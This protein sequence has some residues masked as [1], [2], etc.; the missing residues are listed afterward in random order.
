L[1][2]EISR[3][4][5]REIDSQLGEGRS[6]NQSPLGQF[7][8]RL[9]LGRLTIVIFVASC[10][11]Y[12]LSPQ[13]A[14]MYSDLNRGAEITHV[15]L[16]LVQQG[17]FAHPFYYPTGAT[18][19]TAPVYVLLYALVGKLFG[20]GWTG[21][22]VIWALNVGFLALQLAL[23]PVL[24]DRL[25]LGAV[26]G[27]IAA[28]I[29]AV[30]QP[31]RVLPQWESLFTGALLVVLCVMTLSHFKTPG[32][33]RRSLLLGL[34]WGVAILANPQCVLLL[35]VWPP[36]AAMENTPEMLSRARRAMVVVV[37]GAALACLPWFIRNFQQF[38]AVFFVRDNFGV[39]LF[40]SNN[41]CAR[42]TMLENLMSGCH[43]LTHP[44]G[45]P[46]IAAEAVEKGEIRF[47]Q[48]MLHRALS[49]ISSNPRAFAWLTAQRFLRFWFP[50]LGSYRYGIP[51][52]IL[53]IFSFAGL[54]W[55]YREHRRAALLFASTLIVYPLVHYLMQFEARYRYPIF[56]A[57]LL[58][59]AYAIVKIVHW[60]RKAGLA[61]A[62]AGK[63]EHE[64]AP[65]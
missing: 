57:T 28:G 47:N 35:F 43:W 42:P 3:S 11:V 44:Y 8:G 37:A 53:T 52:G 21:A 58:P 14:P 36:I 17:N 56:W 23:L 9:S 20:I 39:E 49:W 62:S 13:G 60:P 30:V 33:W 5:I 61:K 26:P 55:M 38:H 32:D 12:A 46:S 15:G 25:G 64:M 31:Y 1:P 59:A 54:V 24:S 10:F 2:R 34:L 29:G 16:N 50:Y 63:E 48:E 6:M 51:M 27:A 45:N 41:P 4:D 40:T 19:H 65:V 22:M 18:A 7:G